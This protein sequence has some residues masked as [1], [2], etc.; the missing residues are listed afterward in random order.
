MEFHDFYKDFPDE[1]VCALIIK[2][3]KKQEGVICKNCNNLEHYWKKDKKS[4]ECKNCN[5][6]TSLKSGTIMEHSN[7]PFRYWLSSITFFRIMQ[8]RMSALALQK[9]FGH[10]RYEPIWSMLKKIKNVAESDFFIQ[11]I[12]DYIVFDKNSVR[13]KSTIIF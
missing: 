11:R 5:F 13:L 9:E 6:R 4:F 12:P 10:K 8:E 1:L 2:D 3:I 7:L